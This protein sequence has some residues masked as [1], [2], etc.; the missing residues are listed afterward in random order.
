MK[1]IKKKKTRKQKTPK[2]PSNLDGL[3]CCSPLGCKESA[4]TEKM[5]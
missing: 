1:M 3:A 4:M 5:N 2:N